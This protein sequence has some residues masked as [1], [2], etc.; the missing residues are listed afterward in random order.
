MSWGIGS[1]GI[2]SW[3]GSDFIV[4]AHNP[5]DGSTGISRIPTISFT[6]S[7]QNGNVVLGSISLTANGVALITAGSFTGQSF[8]TIDAT[9]PANVVV[10]ATLL[11]T[12]NPLTTISIEVNALNSTN[13]AAVDN[14]WQ[15]TT[16]G[17]TTT[18]ITSIVRSFERI[19]RVG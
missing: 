10:S 19:N 15:F 9:D 18:F 4:S 2:S 6:L 1:Y 5:F 11:Y 12:L 8:G 14:T 13:S 7:S 3:G 16:N 17:A